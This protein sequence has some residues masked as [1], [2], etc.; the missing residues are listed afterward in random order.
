MSLQTLIAG[1]IRKQYRRYVCTITVRFKSIIII[2]L[3]AKD[4]HG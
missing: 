3:K 1:V 4:E 2:V